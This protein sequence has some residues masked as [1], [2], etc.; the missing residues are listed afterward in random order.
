MVKPDNQIVN[1]KVVPSA[2]A[3]G[4]LHG[5]VGYEKTHMYRYNKSHL[6]ENESFNVVSNVSEG[7]SK[8]EHE[9]ACEQSGR[10]VRPFLDTLIAGKHL[11][12]PFSRER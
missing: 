3:L 6:S 12:D 9:P 4:F 11:S 1:E 8:Q 7:P 10:R 2:I 5:K